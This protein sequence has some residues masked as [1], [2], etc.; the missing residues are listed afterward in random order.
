MLSVT[1]SL[2]LLAL[3][4]N[5]IYTHWNVL[6]CL[7]KGGGLQSCF[8]NTHARFAAIC[9]RLYFLKKST[10]WNI[11]EELYI[12]PCSCLFASFN[13]SIS[14][15]NLKGWKRTE[16][17]IPWQA[18]YTNPCLPCLPCSFLC[19]FHIQVTKVFIV[20]Q[21]NREHAHIYFC[22]NSPVTYMLY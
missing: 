3:P 19:L 9:I 14:T 15:E 18:S 13:V 10:Y 5:Q 16:Q 21:K 17:V 11:G 4:K 22:R 20:F 6:Q 1:V 7:E 2:A 12:I 8:R